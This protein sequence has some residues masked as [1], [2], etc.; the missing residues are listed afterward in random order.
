MVENFLR[1]CCFGFQ[2]KTSRKPRFSE[3][4]PK[5]EVRQPK[6][7]TSGIAW[8]D[9]SHPSAL[10]SAAAEGNVAQIRQLLAAGAPVDRRDA[11]GR[12]PL[13]R[14]ALAGESDAVKALLEHGADAWAKDNDGN[15]L[16]H[17]AASYGRTDAVTALLAHRSTYWIFQRGSSA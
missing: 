12:T 16:L 15:S 5:T 6:T 8:T 10:H 1:F 9:D 4:F 2:P 17:W 7:R 13:I 11:D 3:V 14:A